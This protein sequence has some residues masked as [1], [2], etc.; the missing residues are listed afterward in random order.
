MLCTNFDKKMI[1]NIFFRASQMSVSLSF[2]FEIIAGVAAIF[3]TCYRFY[4]DRSILHIQEK[5]CCYHIQ[6]K[7]YEYKDSSEMVILK[8]AR[9]NIERKLR[10]FSQGNVDTF[11]LYIVLC[12]DGFGNL[13]RFLTRWKN[14]HGKHRSLYFYSIGINKH[15]VISSAILSD[16]CLTQKREAILT[17]LA[18]NFEVTNGDELLSNLYVYDNIPDEIKLNIMVFLLSDLLHDVK[19]NIVRS[20]IKDYQIEYNPLY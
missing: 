14:N 10:K 8:N 15:S 17:L 13:E 5:N 20:L 3:Y 19:T 16:N 11:Q 1:L 6:E 4:T 2:P 18:Y 9:I 7:R 12:R